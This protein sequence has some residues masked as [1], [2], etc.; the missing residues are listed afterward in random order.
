[1]KKSKN[2]NN[3]FLK[4][5]VLCCF[6]CVIMLF[7]CIPFYTIAE[8]V[9]ET[10]E[11]TQKTPI[12]IG[13]PDY[14]DES[15]D[16]SELRQQGRGEKSLE[17]LKR[18]SLNVTDL[19]EMISIDEAVQKG[20]V[21]R[22]R[23]QENSLYTVAFQNKNG[24]K[25]VYL[26]AD[27]VKY[28]DE[29]GVVRDKSTKVQPMADG[30]NAYAMIHNSVRVYFSSSIEGG[31]TLCYNNYVIQMIPC[32]CSSNESAILFDEERNTIKYSNVFSSENIALEYQTMMQGLK[33]NIVLN[34]Y[35]GQSVFR[36]SLLAEGLKATQQN[37]T[38]ILQ[39]E[40]GKKV[41]GFGEIIVK[42]STGNETLGTRFFPYQRGHL[43]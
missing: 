29:N 12:V 1:M 2:Y 26:F 17:E 5:K 10:T 7:S 25:T 27:P 9:K 35:T 32:D 34:Q 39:T 28:K 42:D 41:G 4:I 31:V 21:N 43:K 20:H 36:F 14:A 38:W 37:H 33:E 40:S 18:M 16:L 8:N 6:L 3:T 11:E 15:F 30:A 22:L 19:P 13:E 23:E 24:G